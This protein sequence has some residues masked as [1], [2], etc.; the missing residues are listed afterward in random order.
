MIDPLGCFEELLRAQFAITVRV[1]FLK[2][3]LHVPPV[4]GL[5]MS[6]QPYV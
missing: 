4:W 2:E 3:L 6:W 1:D 5:D